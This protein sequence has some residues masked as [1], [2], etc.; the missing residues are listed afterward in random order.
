MTRR[1]WSEK[2][3]IHNKISKREDIIITVIGTMKEK[4][5]IS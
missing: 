4:Y 5:K 1:L 2:G 3:N